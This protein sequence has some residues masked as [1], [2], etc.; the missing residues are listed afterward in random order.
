M[1]NLG[2]ILKERNE[3]KEAEELLSSAVHIQPDFAAAWMNLGI[4]QNSLKKLD[5]AEQSYRNAIRFRKKYPD[6]YYN[7]G[8]LGGFGLG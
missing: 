7:L 5:E 8:R 1:N 6:C 4:V 2:N 3:L